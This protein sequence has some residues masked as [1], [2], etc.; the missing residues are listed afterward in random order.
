MCRPNV[1]GRLQKYSVMLEEHNITYRPRTSMKGQ[2]LADF[3]AEIP[4]ESPP[5]ASVVETQQVPWTLFTDGSSCV[6]GPVVGLILT[7]PEETEF[8]YALRF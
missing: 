7:S 3:F 4:N 8:T 2:V 6:D 5:D 1:V